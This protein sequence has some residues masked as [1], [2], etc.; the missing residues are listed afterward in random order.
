MRRGETTGASAPLIP[1]DLECEPSHL[2]DR[3]GV[4]IRV[5]AVARS[6]RFAIRTHHEIVSRERGDQH[7]ER[8]ARQMKVGDEAIDRSKRVRGSNEYARVSRAGVNRA[9]LV[10]HR[11]ERTYC[12]RTY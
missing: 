5:E 9:V 12:R 6:H 8:G 7:D 3:H 11:L 10:G 2:H 4:A 1:L